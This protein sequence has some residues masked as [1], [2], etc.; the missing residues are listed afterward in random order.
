[1]VILLMGDVELYDYEYDY[2][3]R[4]LDERGAETVT[5]DTGEWPAETPATYEVSER[6]VVLGERVDPASVS[7]VFTMGDAFDLPRPAHYGLADR[8]PRAAQRQIREW[9]S[10][11]QSLV[12]VFETHGARVTVALD[13][14][15]WDRIRPWMVELYHE[16][17]LPVPETTFTNDPD[18]LREFADRHGPVFVTMVN[19]GSVPEPLDRSALTDELL[20]TLSTAPVKAQE[21]VPGEDARG[22]VIDGE[23]VA[24]IRY[25]YDVDA[26]S[27]KRPAV[28]LGDIESTRID[29]EP[30]LH[31]AVRR[32]GELTPSSFT[33]VDL[34]LTD[35]GFVVLESNVPGRFGFHDRTGTTDVA[36]ALADYLTGGD[37]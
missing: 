35:D 18:R 36:G 32:A 34:R 37:R 6:D 30:A 11:F 17:G 5:V 13:E 31:D 26:I 15:Y 3:R 12:S 8:D 27:W 1:M 10:L 14:T 19:G 7:G 23:V 33:A 24:V 9:R 29:P 28:D 22:Y 20:A 2:V 16:S 21:F 4:A 25:D